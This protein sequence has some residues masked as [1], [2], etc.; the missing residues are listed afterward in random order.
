MGEDERKGEGGRE[1]ADARAWWPIVSPVLFGRANFLAALAR[2]A[3]LQKPMSSP[4]R[5]VDNVLIGPPYRAELPVI[6]VVVCR[7]AEPARWAR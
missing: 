1:R 5:G 7:A 6:P 3:Q 4:S 2:L